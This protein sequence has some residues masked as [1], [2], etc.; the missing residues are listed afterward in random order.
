MVEEDIVAHMAAA[1][2]AA[3]AQHT[4]LIFLTVSA[5]P[6]DVIL[7]KGVL[8]HRSLRQQEHCVIADDAV[9]R[10]DLVK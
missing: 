8:A 5:Y 7:P 2:E 6:H 1:V 10:L 3:V 9:A 4:C